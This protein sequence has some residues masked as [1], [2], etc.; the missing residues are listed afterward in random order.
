MYNNSRR[1]RE[2]KIRAWVGT[3]GLI[4]TLLFTNLIMHCLEVS[5]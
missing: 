5:I 3:I 2:D 1:E 4:A